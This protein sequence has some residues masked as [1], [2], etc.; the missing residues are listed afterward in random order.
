MSQKP[1]E[2]RMGNGKGNPEYL[3]SEIQP[4]KVLYEMDGVDEELAARRSA[5]RGEAAAAHAVRARMA[6]GHEP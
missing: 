6:A 3:V 2:V 4:G 1:A 5:R